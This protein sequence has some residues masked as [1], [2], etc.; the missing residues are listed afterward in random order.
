MTQVEMPLWRDLCLWRQTPVCTADRDTIFFV[1]EGEGGT[2]SNNITVKNVLLAGKEIIRYGF[3]AYGGPQGQYKS[4]YSSTKI[5]TPVQKYLFQYNW[6]IS[7]YKII[8]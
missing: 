5:S 2:L 4:I 1:G 6:F 7:Q 3:D 8:S